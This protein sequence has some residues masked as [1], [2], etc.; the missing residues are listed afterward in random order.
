MGRLSKTA[1]RLRSPPLW[2]SSPQIKGL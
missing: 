1:V 2:S